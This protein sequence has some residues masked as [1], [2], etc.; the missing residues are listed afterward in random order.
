MA[1]LRDVEAEHHQVPG[2]QPQA[3]EF[4][5]CC[6]TATVLTR[7]YPLARHILSQQLPSQITESK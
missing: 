4:P 7:D 3:L 5:Q 6:S 2:G 1:E